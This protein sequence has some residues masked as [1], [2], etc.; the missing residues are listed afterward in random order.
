MG[1]SAYE[2]QGLWEVRDRCHNP[3]W[4]K[5]QRQGSIARA[6]KSN[7]TTSKEEGALLVT[8]A[9]HKDLL[10]GEVLGPT[11]EDKVGAV[12][13]VSKKKKKKTWLLE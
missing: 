5:A 10:V 13:S 1:Q 12:M 6:L 8:R 4:T 9:P 3:R 2:T 11:Q 7:Y